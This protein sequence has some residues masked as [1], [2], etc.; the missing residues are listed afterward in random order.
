M[1][2]ILLSSISISFGAGWVIKGWKEDSKTIK[3][4]NKALAKQQ[5]QHEIDLKLAKESIK[6]KEV[7][8]YKTRTIIKKVENANLN[9]CPKLPADFVR[10]LNEAR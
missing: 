4:I 6:V 10:L 9:T 5:K 2:I 1:L 3:A 7:I 8:K